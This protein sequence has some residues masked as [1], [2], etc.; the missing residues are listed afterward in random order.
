M[1]DDIEYQR[2]RVIYLQCV[3]DIKVYRKIHGVSLQ[4]TQKDSL[5]QPLFNLYKEISGSEPE[6]SAEEIMQRHYLTRWKE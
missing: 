3:E 5:Y 4:D 2:L 6:F 1:F